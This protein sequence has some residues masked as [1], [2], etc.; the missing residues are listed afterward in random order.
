M[1][2]LKLDLS[3]A[4]TYRAVLAEREKAADETAQVVAA[5]HVE[6]EPLEP[7]RA[8]VRYIETEP[9]EPVRACVRYIETE[10]RE[11][12]VAYAKYVG[13]DQDD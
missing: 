13:D 1:A 6:T 7:V 4:P 2:K 10:P 3:Q 8:C 9:L 11:H 12:I 5:C